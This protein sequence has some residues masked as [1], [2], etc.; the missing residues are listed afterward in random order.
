MSSSSPSRSQA[1]T[2]LLS[3]DMTPGMN[4]AHTRNTKDPT[5]RREQPDTFN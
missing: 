4:D 5:K 1:V 3:A 2:R